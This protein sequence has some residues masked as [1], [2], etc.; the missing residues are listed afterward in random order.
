VIRSAFDH[1]GARVGRRD[2]LKLGGLTVSMAALVAACGD[3]SGEVAEPGR[4][5][6]LPPITDPPEYAVDTAVLLRTI[7]SVENTAVYAYEQLL[8][9]GDL[10][11]ELTEIVTRLADDH[12]AVAE[13]M[14]ELTVS[15]GGVAWACTNPWMMERGIE[16]ILAAVADSD[17]PERDVVNTAIA[18]ENLTAATNQEIAVEITDA[19]GSAASLRAAITESRHSAAIVALVRGPEGY[20]SPTISGGDPPS[21]DEG[22]PLQFSIPNRFGSIGQIDLVV[23]K[24]NEN[25][26]RES[27]SLQTPSLNSYIYNELEPTC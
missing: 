9:T 15:A 18:I 5:G 7:S 2:A 14:G 20:V 1:A 23:G 6:Y 11:A 16:P 13:E 26:V 22:I 12:R 25:G 4:V 24:P 27:F 10:D 17:E 8:A 19:D 21:D 3:D